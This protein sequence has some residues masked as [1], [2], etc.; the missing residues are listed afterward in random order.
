[1]GG[2]R[3]KRPSCTAVRVVA[4][5]GKHFILEGAYWNASEGLTVLILPLLLKGV[6]GTGFMLLWMRV[7]HGTRAV[8][9]GSLGAHCIL[10][11]FIAAPLENMAR[12]APARSPGGGQR[13]VLPRPT[14]PGKSF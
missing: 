1:M 9:L 6:I 12:L 13:R 11:P 7:K 5:A 2:R 10:L 14:R 3:R 4:E 8:Y